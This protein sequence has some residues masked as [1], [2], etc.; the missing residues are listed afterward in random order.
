M[1]NAPREAPHGFHL[2]CL[3]QLCFEHKPFFLGPFELSNIPYYVAEAVRPPGRVAHETSGRLMSPYRTILTDY[4]NLHQ[5]GLSGIIYAVEYL[6]NAFGHFRSMVLLEIRPDHFFALESMEP[7]CRIIDIRGVPLQVCFY[8]ALFH[9]L[10]DGAVFLL[11]FPQSILDI[12]PV[13][14]VPDQ[15]AKAYRF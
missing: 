9:R 15:I 3:K 7:A 2:L 8:Q 1:G 5:L 14:H 11:A 12:F 10:E 13:R 6:I 4:F